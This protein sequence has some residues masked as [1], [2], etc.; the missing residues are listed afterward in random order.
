MIHAP[1][2]F[3]TIAC[4][5]FGC[6]FD[7]RGMTG[8]LRQ[9]GRSDAETELFDKTRWPRCENGRS[10]R[11]TSA[12]MADVMI[13]DRLSRRGTRE[14]T[15]DWRWPLSHRF[16]CPHAGLTHPSIPRL[17][18]SRTTLALLRAA[19]R[20]PSSCAAGTTCRARR[21]ARRSRSTPASYL[22]TT[23]SCLVP[24]SPR[25]A[26]AAVASRS[27]RRRSVRIPSPRPSGTSLAAACPL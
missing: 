25:S 7:P 2:R 13:G 5:L 4:V 14:G 1:L 27:R 17:S 8:N 20:R 19:G 24:T 12:S 11:G 6:Y 22:P 21:R 16:S 18:N 10:S 23:S 3:C 15:D 26:D 9:S